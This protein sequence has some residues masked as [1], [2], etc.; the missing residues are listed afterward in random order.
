[1]LLLSLSLQPLQSVLSFYHFDVLWYHFLPPRIILQSFK[2]P[3][4]SAFSLSAPYQKSALRVSI[5]GSVI[6]ELDGESTLRPPFA[7]EKAE[8]GNQLPRIVKSV[9]RGQDLNSDVLMPK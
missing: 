8:R 1:M 6:L 4:N 2:E 7:E 9:T 3:E 5:Y